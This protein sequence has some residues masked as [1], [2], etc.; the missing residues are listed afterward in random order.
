[1]KIKHSLIIS[2]LALSATVSYAQNVGIGTN[3][4]NAPLQ[5]ANTAGNRKIVLLESANNDHQFYGVGINT[6]MFR[7]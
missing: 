2:F 7:Y 6:S 5:L 3:T 4:P 1:M